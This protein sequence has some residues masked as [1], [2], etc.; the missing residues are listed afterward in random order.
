[1]KVLLTGSRGLLGQALL[2]AMQARGYTVQALQRDAIWAAT[3]QQLCDMVSGYALLIHA[4]ANTHVEQCEQQPDT[5]YRDNLLLTELLASAASAH[6]MRMVFVSSTGVYGDAQQEPYCEYHAVHPTTHH[7]RSKHLAEQAVL[8]S[9]PHN[10]VVR[11]GWLFGGRFDNPKNF[12]A[13]RLEELQRA[14]QTGQA[15]LSNAEQ[16][17]SP[18]S[19]NDV[20]L[21]LLELAEQGRSGVY[22]CVNTG[23][24]NRHA[25]VHEIG[26]LANINAEVLPGTASGFGRIAKVSFNEAALNW[27]MNALGL[28]PMPDWRDALAVTVQ[29][30]L[31]DQT[32]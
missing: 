24:A 15:V 8:R 18:S 1:M 9:N 26:R 19:C 20:A 3:P 10:L 30:L 13:R 23:Q 14:A 2:Q 6:A 29:R 31:A 32:T 28:Q 11:T 16:F 17:G 5:C 7:H 25:Y 12:V 4:A 27:K 22:N 21:R